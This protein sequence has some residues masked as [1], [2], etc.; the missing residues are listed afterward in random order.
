MELGFIDKLVEAI[1]ALARSLM[2][3]NCWPPAKGR[4]APGDESR[5]G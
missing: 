5:S 3:E 1:C 4:G 2:S